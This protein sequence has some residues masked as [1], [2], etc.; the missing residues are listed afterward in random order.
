MT[1]TDKNRVISQKSLGELFSLYYTGFS[2]SRMVLFEQENKTK[3]HNV[4]HGG[5]NIPDSF[6]NHIIKNG[7]CLENI[8][9]KYCSNGQ[10]GAYLTSCDN[11]SMFSQ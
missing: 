6:L 8:L 2:D 11:I 7:P 5:M 10:M 3:N 1:A 4:L 9:K